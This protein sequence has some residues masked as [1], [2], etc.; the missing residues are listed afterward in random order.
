MRCFRSSVVERLL[1]KEEVKSSILFGS[2]MIFLGSKSQH[3]LLIRMSSNLIAGFRELN[4][5]L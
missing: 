5:I 3:R 2:S 4:Y 1:G